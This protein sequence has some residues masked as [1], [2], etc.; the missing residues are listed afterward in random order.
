MATQPTTLDLIRALGSVP[1]DMRSAQAGIGATQQ[2]VDQAKQP[3][4]AIAPIQHTLM[5]QDLTKAQGPYGSRPGEM[6]LDAEGNPISGFSGVK[7]KSK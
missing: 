6:R 2:M 5:P 3:P 1:N 7:R 4:V